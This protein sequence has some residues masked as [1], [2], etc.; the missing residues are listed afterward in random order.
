MAQPPE[1]LEFLRAPQHNSRGNIEQLLQDI[2]T[3]LKKD[4]RIRMRMWV[5]DLKA[6]RDAGEIPSLSSAMVDGLAANVDIQVLVRAWAKQAGPIFAG[7]R[8]HVRPTATTYDTALHAKMR[9]AQ[10]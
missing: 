3:K 9:R 10:I 8:L 7:G 5:Q 4:D 1:I 2:V 6:K